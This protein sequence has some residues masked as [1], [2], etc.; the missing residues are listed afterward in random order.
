MTRIVLV[1]LVLFAASG[2]ALAQDD[3]K[4]V[5]EALQ[6]EWK[7][8]SFNKA[9]DETPADELAGAKMVFAG[10][11]VTVTFR[12]KDDPAGFKID[13]K[14]NPPAIDI[15]P[16]TN[17]K[18]EVVKGIYKLEKDKLTICFGPDGA[19]RP[20]EFKAGKTA[21]VMVLERVKK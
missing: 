21:S 4:K 2:L 11:M 18:N 12:K 16:K 13:T 14:A 20:A 5:V 19:G 9:G 6:G 15:I 3:P 10:E 17:P 1:P 8:V 7:V